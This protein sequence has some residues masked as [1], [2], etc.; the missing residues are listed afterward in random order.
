MKRRAFTLIELMIVIVILAIILAIAIPSMAEQRNKLYRITTS[1][2]L[3][4][5]AVRIRSD[6]GCIRYWLADDTGGYIYGQFIVQE[7]RQAEAP[8]QPSAG[9]RVSR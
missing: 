3:V 4:I 8:V 5:D 1:T 2:G 7:I 9:I 6:A